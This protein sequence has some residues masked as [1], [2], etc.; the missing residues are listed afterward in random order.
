MEKYWCKIFNREITK[1]EWRSIYLNG[2]HQLPSTKLVEFGYKMIHG[3]LVSRVI[4]YKWKRTDSEMCIYCNEK[5]DVKHMYFD[6]R[7]IQKI[8]N[9]VGNILKVDVKW[10]HV[11]FG[12][13]QD[14]TI[15]R[16][17][18]LL[19]KV[20][21]YAIF[22]LWLSNLDNMQRNIP[23]SVI[24]KC[25]TKDIKTWDNIVNVSSFDRTHPSFKQ[26]W[27]TI[28]KKLY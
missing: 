4:L 13:T 22:K 14:I 16:V 8:W 28:T 6:C 10:K 15:H 20:I 21:L 19:F 9:N 24:W 23:Y 7:Q 5:E 17:R 12:F 1:S 18:N 26:M 2:I 27:I 25:I 3:L 11:V